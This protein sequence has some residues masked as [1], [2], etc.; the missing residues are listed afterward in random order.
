MT[1]EIR[2]ETCLPSPSFPQYFTSL[3]TVTVETVIIRSYMLVCL[4]VQT[5]PLKQTAPVMLQG[6]NIQYEDTAK[7]VPKSQGLK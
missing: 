2:S 7:P 1:F 6:S 4:P 3:H 5:D